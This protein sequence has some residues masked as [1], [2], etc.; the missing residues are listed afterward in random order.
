M[1][2]NQELDNRENILEC[3]LDL[4]YQ[5]G[6]D[7]VGV[8]EIVTKAGITKPTLYY[9]FKSKYGLLEALL[10]E[11]CDHMITRL[12]E[13]ATYQGDL[14]VTLERYAK[15]LFSIAE[16]DLRFYYLF[17][18]LFYSARENDTY[19]AVLPYIKKQFSIIRG[20]FDE[21][22]GFLGN[23]NGRQE[24][25]AIGFSGIL[26]HYILLYYEKEHTSKRLIDD[27]KIYMLVHQFMYGIVV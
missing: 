10:Q 11:R 17:L 25:F 6:Y 5:K 4:F 24:Q 14:I 21:A 7:A 23:M 8:Q 9:Y 26:N 1:E 20:I 13:A 12:Q 22:A 3:A 27:H 19:K 2:H 15:A 18:S 16:D